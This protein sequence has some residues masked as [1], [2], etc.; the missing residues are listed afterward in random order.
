MPER[1][2]E[3]SGFD[4]STRGVVSTRSSLEPKSKQFCE[5]ISAWI[6]DCQDDHSACKS[7]NPLGTL[8]SRVID[9]GSPDGK[10]APR[11]CDTG[12]EPGDYIALSHCWGGRQPL[13]TTKENISSMRTC[14]PWGELPNTF[15]DAITVTRMLGLRYVW[16]DSLCIV[17]DDAQ[18]WEREAAKMALIFEAAY[19]TIAATAASNGSVCIF[20]ESFSSQFDGLKRA[21]PHPIPLRPSSRG[22]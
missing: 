22:C 13:I 9:V 18:D 8:P 3:T 14:I 16:I 17:Q 7:S 1:F 2:K 21:Y 10:T 11:L 5:M 20:R 6:K 19:L 4:S 12:G 15:Q